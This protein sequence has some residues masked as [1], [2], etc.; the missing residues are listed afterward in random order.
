MAQRAGARP[1]CRR[2][3]L[4]LAVPGT[5]H[6][7]GCNEGHTQCSLSHTCTAGTHTCSHIAVLTQPAHT[8][9]HTHAHM[10]PARWADAPLLHNT[11]PTPLSNVGCCAPRPQC[12]TLQGG[13]GQWGAEEAGV[14]PSTATGS[15]MLPSCPYRPTPTREPGGCWEAQAPTQNHFL[16]SLWCRTRPG[17]R[18]TGVPQD[19]QVAQVGAA[20]TTRRGT[21]EDKTWASLW[22]ANKVVVGS[23]MAVDRPAW[24]GGMVWHHL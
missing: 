22:P 10:T 8:C 5:G 24:T 23:G 13:M 12:H 18:D 2:W 6:M 17:W 4:A 3:G 19:I 16:L 15:P 11:P 9:N 21:A 20:C 14:T 7:G 1:P